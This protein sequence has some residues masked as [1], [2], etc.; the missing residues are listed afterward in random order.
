MFLSLKIEETE[1]DPNDPFEMDRLNRKDEIENLT[2]LVCNLNSPAVLAINSQWGT[3]KTTFIKL[4]EQHLKEE[5]LDSVYFSAW[6]TDFSEDPLIAFLGEINASLKPLIGKS[7]KSKRAWL[8]AKA[9]G[10]QIAKRAVPTL[11][12]VAT[13][14]VLDTDKLIEG[15]LSKLAGGLAGDALDNY[16]EEKKPL[17][18]FM[19]LW[20]S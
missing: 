10:K 8:M 1:I 2:S 9:A 6:E 7:E 19:S 17:L 15:E 5:K 14:G 3:G 12:K 20:R 18:N 4:W 16:L 13:A 11:I